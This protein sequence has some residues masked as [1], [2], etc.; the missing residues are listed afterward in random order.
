MPAL[1]MVHLVLV[2]MYTRQRVSSSGEYW[3]N[4]KSFRAENDQANDSRMGLLV[5]SRPC[6]APSLSLVT[7]GV[8]GTVRRT[9]VRHDGGR[10]SKPD[11]TEDE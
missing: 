9:P 4:S 6:V 10:G 11:R 3:Q 2:P 8:W 7:P 1:Y 5:F